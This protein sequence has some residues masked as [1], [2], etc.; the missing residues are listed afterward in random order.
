LGEEEIVGRHA[1]LA[2]KRLEMQ[3][4]DN[5]YSKERVRIQLDVLFNLIAQNDNLIA[6][7][8]ARASEQTARASAQ[9][10]SMMKALTLVALL[11]LPGNFVAALFSAPLFY[12]DDTDPG[13]IGVRTKPQFGLFWVVALPLTAAAFFAYAAWW[14]VQKRRWGR[15]EPRDIM[16]HY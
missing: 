13:S 14:Q 1:R 12:W 11:F 5:E 2:D 7:Q 4:L 6:Q 10:S 9:D 3:M 15:G 16:N 8:T